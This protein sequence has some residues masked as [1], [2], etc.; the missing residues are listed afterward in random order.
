MEK[1]IFNV[2]LF[3][4]SDSL[5]KIKNIADRLKVIALSFVMKNSHQYVIP[6]TSIK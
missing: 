2:Y 5:E 3:A 4:I 6:R 1:V